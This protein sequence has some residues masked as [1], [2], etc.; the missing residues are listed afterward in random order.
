MR[1]TFLICFVAVATM[2][3]TACN[4]GKDDPAAPAEEKVSLT[5]TSWAGGFGFTME[6]ENMTGQAKVDMT[7]TFQGDTTGAMGT[8]VNVVMAGT[9]YPA[10][11]ETSDFTYVFDGKTAGTITVPYA[12]DSADVFDFVYSKTDETL[13]LYTDASEEDMA[14]GFP[15][16]ILFKKQ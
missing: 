11:D 3:M 5:G 8:S 4:K 7:L 15:S 16:E 9:T 6:D 14:E 10:G 12:E 1:K 2:F 13:L